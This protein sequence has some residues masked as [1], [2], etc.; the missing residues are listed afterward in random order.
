MGELIFDVMKEVFSTFLA[1]T[2]GSYMGFAT[3]RTSEDFNIVSMILNAVRKNTVS[4]RM[5]CP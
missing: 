4:K 1:E 2:V 3:E 5:G